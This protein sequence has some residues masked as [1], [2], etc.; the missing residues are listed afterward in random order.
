MSWGQMI[1]KSYV[2][3]AWVFIDR[4]VPGILAGV[5]LV[6]NALVAGNGS[7]ILRAY[8][9]DLHGPTVPYRCDD[10]TLPRFRK[11]PSP[12]LMNTYL[13]RQ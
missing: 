13:Q 8:G 4:Q 5:S 12:L 3:G 11:P 6:L 7:F 10:F 9:L 2:F 1:T